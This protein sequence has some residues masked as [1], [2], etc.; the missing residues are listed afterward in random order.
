MFSSA[1]PRVMRW[2]PWFIGLVVLGMVFVAEH[3]VMLIMPRVLPEDSAYWLDA[4]TDAALLSLIVSPLMWWA[5]VGPLKNLNQVRTRFIAAVLTS[6]EEARRLIARELHD[7][8]RQSLTLLV[9]S[10]RSWPPPLTDEQ[11]QRLHD[12]AQIVQQ[13][14][15][16]HVRGTDIRSGLMLQRKRPLVK[17]EVTT[18]NQ[19]SQKGQGWLSVN[20]PADLHKLNMLRNPSLPNMTTPKADDFQSETSIHSCCRRSTGRW[21]CRV[22]RQH[23]QFA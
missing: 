5:I 9:T 19:S 18:P 20:T 2:P 15:K 17:L 1:P 7:S 6:Q 23:E 10:L 22:R 21:C 11:Q 16:L 4:L 8:A 13:T 3:M 12:L 14:L